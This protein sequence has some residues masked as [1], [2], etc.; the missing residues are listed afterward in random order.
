[1]YYYLI[2]SRKLKRSHHH[3]QCLQYCTRTVND[4]IKSIF[5]SGS[6]G[7]YSTKGPPRSPQWTSSIAFTFESDKCDLVSVTVWRT[8]KVTYRLCY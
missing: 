2:N 3:L 6:D 1:M 7:I 5:S 4:L 8:E